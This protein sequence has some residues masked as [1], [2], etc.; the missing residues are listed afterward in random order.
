M[1]RGSLS[2][3]LFVSVTETNVLLRH[4]GAGS[5]IVRLCELLFLSPRLQHRSFTVP[6]RRRPNT[7]PRIVLSCRPLSTPVDPLSA[8][9]MNV[10]TQPLSAEE[11]VGRIPGRARRRR[12]PGESNANISIP[13]SPP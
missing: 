3:L 6:W 2:G 9:T 13:F 7:N 8:P 12:R 10:R 1:V 5:A 11:Q 4:T